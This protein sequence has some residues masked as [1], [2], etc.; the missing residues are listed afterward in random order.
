ML[1]NIKK[2]W[3]AEISV[4]G[5]FV[6]KLVPA[7]IGLSA[8]VVEVLTYCNT[9]PGDVVSAELKSYIGIFGAVCLFLGNFL[10]KKPT[11]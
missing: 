1:K 8:L 4:W 2:S 3:N 10:N 9:I 7:L 6:S 5:H 11:V